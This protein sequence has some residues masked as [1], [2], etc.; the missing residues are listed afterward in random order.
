MPPPLLL[1]HT[2]SAMQL[3]ACGGPNGLTHCRDNA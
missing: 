1:S 3:A 2:R